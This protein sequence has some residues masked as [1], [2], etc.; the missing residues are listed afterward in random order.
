MNVV[1]ERPF[2]TSQWRH[3]RGHELGREVPSGDTNAGITGIKIVIE[4]KRVSKI[5]CGYTKLITT[6]FTSQQNLEKQ[7]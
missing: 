1:C 4:A 3:C 7:D 2:E 5:P 6:C